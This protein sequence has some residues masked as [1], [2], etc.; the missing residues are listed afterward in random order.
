MGDIRPKSMRAFIEVL[1]MIQD[2]DI[3]AN[4][5]TDFLDISY[6]GCKYLQNVNA[7]VWRVNV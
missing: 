6:L 3:Y 2:F 4:E 5:S 7:W 1:E